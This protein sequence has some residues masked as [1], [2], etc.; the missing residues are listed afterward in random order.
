MNDTSFFKQDFL[1][2][3]DNVSDGRLIKV[4]SED[5]ELEEANNRPDQNN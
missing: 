5:P 3:L 1:A 2:G 4:S